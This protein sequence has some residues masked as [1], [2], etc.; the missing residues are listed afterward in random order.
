M[1]WRAVLYISLSIPTVI[2]VHTVEEENTRKTIPFDF[3][4]PRSVVEKGD[5]VEIQF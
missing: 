5:T 2:H 3:Q 4:T 1:G